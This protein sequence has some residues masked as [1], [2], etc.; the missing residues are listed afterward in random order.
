VADSYPAY[1]QGHRKRPRRRRGRRT[2]I[3]L[4]VL[5][6]VLA[7]LLVV[8]DRLAAGFAE[9]A[10]ADQVSQEVE[11]REIQS[12]SPR[13]T[14]GG[15][16]F[17]TQVL[18]GRYESI[19]ILVRDVR[20][21]GQAEGLRMPELAVDARNVSASLET[22]RSGEGEV[23]AETVEGTGVIAYSSVVDVIAQPGLTLSEENGRLLVS[24]PLQ[25][26]GQ[27]LTVRGIAELTVVDGQVLLGFDELTADG[28]P[29]DAVARQAVSA[30]AR[31]IS[32]Q[33]PVPAMPFDLQVREV[34]PLPQGLAVSAIA[35][36]V[37]LNSVT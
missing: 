16:P 32:V 27:E 26:L 4:L 20:P 28:L 30:Y 9:R 3:V 13:V 18:A 23:T 31:Q 6:I 29:D 24:S 5:L 34:R 8:A 10:I 25:V 15:F 35:R 36:E 12:S 19:S 7:G 33:L 22:L 17:L 1:D 37:P 21:V 14:V 11:N 2:L